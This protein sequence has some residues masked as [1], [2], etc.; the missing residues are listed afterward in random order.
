MIVGTSMQVYPA[1]G[2]VHYLP[3]T[4]PIYYIDPKPLPLQV[5]NSLSV[6][7]KKAGE[8][9]PELVSELIEKK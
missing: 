5:P 9:L 8:G 2:L 1:A 3:R 6:I 4:T 7:D